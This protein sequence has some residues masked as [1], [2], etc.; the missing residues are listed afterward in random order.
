M[1]DGVGQRNVEAVFDDGGGDEDVVLVVHEGEHDALELGLGKL[2]VANDDAR[3]RHQ[4]ANLGCEV[5]DSFYAVVDEVN[6]PAA[7]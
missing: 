6:L 5:V 7:L 4:L 1:D 2:A 3:L